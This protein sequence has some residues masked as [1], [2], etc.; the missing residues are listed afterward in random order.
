LISHNTHVCPKPS[1]RHCRQLHLVDYAD[2]GTRLYYSSTTVRVFGLIK[3]EAM[4][5]MGSLISKL[6]NMF[7]LNRLKMVNVDATAA[8]RFACSRGMGMA[9]EATVSGEEG[10]HW[11]ELI[12]SDS[13]TFY[14]STGE[15]F[16]NED[17][18]LTFDAVPPRPSRGVEMTTCIIKPHIIRAKQL[19]DVIA[20]IASLAADGIKIEEVEMVNFD[21]TA[22]ASFFDVYKGLFT[23]YDKMVDQMI[24][25]PSVYVKLTGDNVVE[26]FREFC[27]PTDV[28]VARHLRPKSLR[29]Q[30]GRDR[31]SQLNSFNTKFHMF[32]VNVQIFTFIRI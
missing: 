12:A 16:V 9:V 29:A 20:S 30:F 18:R 11:R 22:A 19:G 7:T 26:S 5:E 10:S 23:Y 4:G 6:Q 27:G 3:P 13:S 24:Q 31:V 28:E 1:C 8:D 15:E 25:G 17:S 14:G 32:I 2:E 21:K